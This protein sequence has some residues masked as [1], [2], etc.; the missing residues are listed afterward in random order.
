MLRALLLNRMLYPLSFS[1]CIHAL[2][3]PNIL[4]LVLLRLVLVLALQVTS[5]VSWGAMT[6]IEKNYFNNTEAKP[7][8]A[9]LEATLRSSWNTAGGFLLTGGIM[10]L[11]SCV[12]SVVY[13]SKLDF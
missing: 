11:I 13:A 12:M 8:V 7:D 10:S 1:T 3:V 9:I 2:P 4:S 6:Q 5:A